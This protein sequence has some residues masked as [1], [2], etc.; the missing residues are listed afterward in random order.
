MIPC[1]VSYAAPALPEQETPR[2]LG[3]DD[4]AFRRG[5]SYGTLLVDLERGQPI[6]MLADRQASTLAAWLKQHPGYLLLA[7]TGQAN[8]RLARSRERQKLSRSLIASTSRKTF[9]RWPNASLRII[10]RPCGRFALSRH[11]PPHHLPWQY[12][13]CGLLGSGEN[14][15]CSK[16]ARRAP[17]RFRAWSRKA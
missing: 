13:I 1:C 14:T 9:Q 16:H 7:E 10:V 17:S 2:I 8:T 11:L 6:E 4:W 15:R 3:V 12:G 5:I